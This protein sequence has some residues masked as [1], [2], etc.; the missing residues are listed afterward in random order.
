[1]KLHELILLSDF[2]AQSVPTGLCGIYFNGSLISSNSFM[3]DDSSSSG[4]DVLALIHMH[5]N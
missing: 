1:M 2:G 4:T 3:V 5:F